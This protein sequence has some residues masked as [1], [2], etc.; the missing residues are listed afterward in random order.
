MGWTAPYG[1]EIGS[2]AALN[3]GL[4][5]RSF[6]MMVLELVSTSLC[7]KLSRLVCVQGMF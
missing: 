5:F 7:V 1:L 3:A 6:A 4:L 2:N